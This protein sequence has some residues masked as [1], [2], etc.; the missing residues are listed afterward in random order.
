MTGRDKGFKVYER[1]GWKE[2]EMME[3]DTLEELVEAL[4]EKTGER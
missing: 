3:A 4:K 2:D 1:H